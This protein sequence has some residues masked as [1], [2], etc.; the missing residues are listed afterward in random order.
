MDLLKERQIYADNATKCE[1]KL[2]E[3]K[4]EEIDKMLIDEEKRKV[5]LNEELAS[6]NIALDEQQNKSNES[7]Q[8]RKLKTNFEESV[9][10]IPYNFK[11][12]R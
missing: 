2:L 3:I 4:I 11:S 9:S 6:I 5:L 1:I 8:E 7:E 12:E 10:R